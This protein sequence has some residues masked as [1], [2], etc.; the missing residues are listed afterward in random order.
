MIVPIIM[1]EMCVKPWLNA[2]TTP[3][4]LMQLVPYLITRRSV[5]VPL[6]PQEIPLSLVISRHLQDASME[7]LITQLSMDSD[8]ITWE[9]VATTSPSLVGMITSM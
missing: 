2:K 8:I 5:L 4:E 6:D 3:V 9:P 1:L 7:I